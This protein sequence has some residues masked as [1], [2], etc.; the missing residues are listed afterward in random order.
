MERV[1]RNDKRPMLQVDDPRAKMREL[2]TARE[3]IYRQA[4][5]H[6]KIARGPHIRTVNRVL[7]AMRAH[8]KS[9]DS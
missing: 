3:P 7:K 4:H 2:M 8:D 6:V 5:I 9:E 1:S